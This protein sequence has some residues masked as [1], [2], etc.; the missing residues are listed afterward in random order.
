VGFGLLENFVA[1]VTFSNGMDK[2]KTYD[3]FYTTLHKFKDDKQSSQEICKRVEELLQ[4][5]KV[6]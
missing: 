2:R 3:V 1:C 6:S 5:K 4:K